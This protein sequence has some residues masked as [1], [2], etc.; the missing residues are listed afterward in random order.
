[1]KTFPKEKILKNEN[2]LFAKW[3][4]NTIS[5]KQS[6]LMQE[7]AFVFIL[8]GKKLIIQNNNTIEVDQHQLL[9]LKKGI[10]EM[11]E[12]IPKNGEFEALVI[13]FKNTFIKYP[14]D[15]LLGKHPQMPF[16][17]LNRDKMIDDYILHYLSYINENENNPALME[18]KINELVILLTERSVQAKVFFNTLSDNYN[19][20]KLLMEKTFKEN[21]TVEQLARLSNRSVS[22]FKRD[23]MLLFKNTPAKWIL[24]KKLDCAR[25]QLLNSDKYIS[26]IAFNCGFESVSHF[27]K[28]FKK[29]YNITPAAFRKFN[30]D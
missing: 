27:N 17:I 4:T 21:H 22:K 7:N 1:M 19:D 12:Y 5:T 24:Q 15:S 8:K 29:N 2:L 11:T 13:Y 3:K 18:L 9:L 28:A 25:F 26:D 14:K 30:M 23:F 6:I 10:H 20:L 16:V